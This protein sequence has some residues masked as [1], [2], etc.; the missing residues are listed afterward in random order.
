[1][2]V[3][4][5]FKRQPEPKAAE[6]LQSVLVDLAR[7]GKPRLGIYGSDGTWHCGVEMN[8]SAIGVDFKVA[9]DFKQPDPLSAALQCRANLHAALA[10]IWGR[11]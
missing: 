1:M 2:T 3:L 6:D 9:S 8:T 7:Y 4:A 10:K 11:P 5:I